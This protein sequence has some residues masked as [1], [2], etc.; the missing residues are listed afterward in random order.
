MEQLGG[1]D[2]MFVHAELHGMP[3]H[4]S[5]LSIYDPSSAVG[6]EVNFRQIIDL[7]EKKIQFDV[8]L[9]R[10]RLLPV[11]FNL[12]QPYWIEDPNFDLVYHIRHIALPKP[13]N[14]QKLC[15]LV[16]NLHAQPLNRSRPLWEAYVIDGIDHIDDIPKGSFALFLKVHHSLMDGRTGMAIYNSLHT[17]KPDDDYLARSQS[18]DDEGRFIEHVPEL[19][20]S[21]LLMRAVANNFHKAGNLA[22]MLGRSVSLF[23]EISLALRR[24]E[25]KQLEKP[26]TRFNGAISP[27]RVVDRIRL[28]MSDIRLV[29]AAFPD[30]TI[31]DI[32]L[33]IVSGALRRYL[34]S[35]DELPDDSLVAAVPIDVRDKEDHRIRGNRISITNISL[36]TDIADPLQRLRA[37][38]REALAGKAYARTLGKN[39]VNEVLDNLYAGVVAWGV[40]TAVESGLLEKFPPANNTIVTNVPGAP[41]PLYLCG[42]RL[43]DSFGMGPLIPNTGLFHTVSTTYDFL[44]VAFTADRQKMEDP[45]FYV[46]C[47]EEAFIELLDAVRAEL[48]QRAKMDSAVAFDENAPPRRTRRRSA[49]NK[50]KPSAVQL[51]AAVSPTEARINVALADGKPAADA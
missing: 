24:K 27:R 42:A 8:P 46:Q 5:S 29:K 14:W 12:D 31:N 47:L 20:T 3:M 35:K 44:T 22:R 21:R 4:I 33:A 16:A 2:A 41:V 36:R 40:R 17:L 13:G 23:G 18:A 26:K 19:N 49:S 37:V 34:K 30:E 11:P 9:L 28:P 48:E 10:Y 43:V 15:S 39:I 25:L 7:F 45:D 51:E 38:H 6:G 32:A 50:L 1:L